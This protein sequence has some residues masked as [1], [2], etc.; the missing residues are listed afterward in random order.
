MYSKW[1]LAYGHKAS[2]LIFIPLDTD[3][4]MALSSKARP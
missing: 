2:D 3:L 4:W 1:H